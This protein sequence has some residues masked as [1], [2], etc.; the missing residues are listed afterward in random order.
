MKNV[1]RD[2]GDRE[3]GLGCVIEKESAPGGKIMCVKV[4]I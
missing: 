3:I 4:G 2:D 1:I